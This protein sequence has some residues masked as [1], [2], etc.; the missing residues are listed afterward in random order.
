[1]K[2]F[3]CAALTL[4]TLMPAAS[5]ANGQG[6]EEAALPAWLERVSLTGTIEGDYAWARRGDIADGGSG[7]A[8]D[9]FLSAV[10]L[11]VGLDLNDYISGFVLLK[12]EDIGSEEETNLMVDE[13]TVAFEGGSLPFYLTLGKRAQ[14]FG[15][16]EN[17]L[18]SD[19]MA[20]D[21]YE[22]ND[23]GVTVGYRGPMDSDIS[24]TL[25]SG[26]EMMERLLGSGLF[27]AEAVARRPG[28]SDG[29]SSFIISASAT[30]AANHLLYLTVFASFLSE[31]GRDGRNSTASAGFNLIPPFL[32][33][34]KATAEYARA[35]R[36][37]RYEGF[38]RSFKES[39]YTLTV[40]YEFVIRRK[41]ALGGGL[42]AERKAHIVKEPLELAARFERFD[43]GGMAAA[44][45][46]SVKDR[47]GLGARYTF[48]EKDGLSAYLAGEVRRTGL[49][50]PAPAGRVAASN[51]E[52]FLRLGFAF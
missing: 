16:F 47:Y 17:H 38:D 25:Y 15:V 20:Q 36:R 43:D 10:E 3:V 42:F 45:V 28:G 46:W 4:I 51:D 37:E 34:L 27:D 41:E 33:N 40:A 23:V 14:P 21:A 26:E 19:P 35:L 31:P 29:A 32:E 22:T 8:S 30:P 1:M 52:A 9:I 48:Y 11:G 50:V 24:I 12:A 6:P 18:V 49:R 2:G 5:K 7:S 13:A 44:G 39:V